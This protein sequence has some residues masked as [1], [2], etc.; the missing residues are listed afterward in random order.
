MKVEKLTKTT[1]DGLE[2][3]AKPYIAWCGTLPGFGCS[4]RPTGS[5]SFVAQYDIGGRNGQTRK[6]TIGTY[7]KLTVDDARKE[8]RIVLA[9]AETGVD[10]A[11][12]RAKK[13]AEMTVAQLCDEYVLRGCRD[14]KA[15]TVATDKGRIARHIKPLLGTKKIGDIKRT[16]V[17]RFFEDVADGKTAADEKTGKH[18]RAIVTGGEGAARR[19]V[20][21]LGGI[22]SYAVEKGYIETN[23]RVGVK[24]GADGAKKDFLKDDQFERLGNALREAETVGIPWQFSEGPNS[25]HAPK[26]NDDPREVVNPYAIAAI[27]LLMLTG[28]RA[29][30]ILTL[31]WN[32]VDLDDDILRL[33]TSKS[34]A[35]D[36]LL[37]RTAAAILRELPRVEGNP[38][39]IVGDKKGRPRS[40]LK[41][42]WKRITDHAGLPGLRLHDL[43]HSFASKGAN[44]GLGIALVSKLLGHASTTTTSRYFHFDDEPTRRG[45]DSIS[46][47]IAAASGSNAGNVVPIKR[48]A[49]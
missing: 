43:R 33:P 22:F 18:G 28:C 3:A 26:R 27:R 7:G 23:P 44:S 42:P 39:V 30:E 12:D 5:K 13:R 16:H 41:R 48:N 11:G 20:R 40:D 15:S 21:L 49:A 29:G 19:T 37:G 24:I 10:V 4:V 34:G 8:A 35:K 38:Y 45:V 1:V 25:K 32:H 2:K 9:K 31:Q 6:V 14:K 17:Q 46:D 47:A 36:V